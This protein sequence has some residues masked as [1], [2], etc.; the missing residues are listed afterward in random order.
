MIGHEYFGIFWS[1]QKIIKGSVSI[2]HS[3]VIS[4]NKNN[5][6]HIKTYEKINTAQE[7]K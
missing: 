5:N 2:D 6:C 1:A 4:L 7:N 3:D